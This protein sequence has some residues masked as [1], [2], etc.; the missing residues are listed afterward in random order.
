MHRDGPCSTE[1]TTEFWVRVIS[2]AEELERKARMVVKMC[3]TF[4]ANDQLRT[5]ALSIPILY[6]GENQHGQLTLKLKFESTMCH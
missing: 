4:P 6:R 1:K 3:S 5:L 2:P